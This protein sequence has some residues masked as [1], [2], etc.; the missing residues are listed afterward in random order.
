M[1]FFMFYSFTKL[2]NFG[3]KILFESREQL[4]TYEYIYNCEVWVLENW[5]M[6]PFYNIIF[7]CI[8]DLEIPSN[9]GY[10]CY[11]YDLFLD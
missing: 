1:F 2:I 7:F 11:G 8:S 9:S 3:Y 4:H 10:N 6:V 5:L